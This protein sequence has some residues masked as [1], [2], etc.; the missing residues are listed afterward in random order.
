MLC[1]CSFSG[2][3]EKSLPSPA[4]ATALHLSDAGLAVPANLPRAQSRLCLA[5]RHKA[6]PLVSITLVGTTLDH[7][8]QYLYTCMYV[9]ICACLYIQTHCSSAGVH[10]VFPHYLHSRRHRKPRAR[11]KGFSSHRFS[12][13]LSRRIY[14]YAHIRV[15]GGMFV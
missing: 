12:T 14:S 3:D 10:S 6:S 1:G 15:L 5:E 9:Y 7:S 13:A 11:E 4:S 2:G 8:A